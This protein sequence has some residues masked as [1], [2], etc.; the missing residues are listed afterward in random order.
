MRWFH[1]AVIAVFAIAILIFAFQNLQ[2]VRIAF[3][4]FSG[5]A[6]LA[7]LGGADLRTR[8]ADRRQPLVA[9]APLARRLAPHAGAFALG[10]GGHHRPG[11]FAARDAGI[12]R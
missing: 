12:F 10:A 7:V 1:V 9:A 11:P 3:L 2:V 6:P 4:G 5:G 8:H